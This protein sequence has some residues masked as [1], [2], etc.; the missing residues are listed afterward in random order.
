MKR[1]FTTLFLVVLAAGLAHAQSA[2]HGMGTTGTIPVWTNNSS[3]IGNSVLTQSGGNV[4]NASGKLA[5][6]QL[7]STV[8]I[9]T[10]PLMVTSTTQVPNLNASSLGGFGPTGFVQNSPM[11]QQSGSFNLSGNGTLGGTLNAGI[12][13]SIGLYQIGGTPVVVASSADDR[14][15][16]GFG[17]LLSNN[18]GTDNTA[19]GFNAL[20]GN[21]GGSNNTAIGSLALLNNTVGAFN[22]ASGAQALLSNVDGTDN[23][24][25]G[26]LALF[27]NTHGG[28]NTASGSKALVSNTEGN[29][30]T[31]IGASALFSNTT[32]LHNTALGADAG[33]FLVTGVSNIMVGHFAGANFTTNESENIDIGNAGTLGDGSV[34]DH[35]VIRVGTDATQDPNCLNT[36]GCQVATFI[37]AIHGVT[38]GSS[39]T[40]AVLV[41][42][43]GQLGTIASSRR[44]K[45]AIQD[46]GAASDGLLRLRPVTFRYKKAF[47]DGTKP[48]Q[49]GLVAEEVAEVY[50]DLVVRGKDGQ[51][52]TV[53]YYKLDAMLL[54]EIQKLAKAHAADQAEI[55]ELKSQ[56]ADQ[57]KQGQEQQAAMRQLLDQVRVIQAALD[58]TSAPKTATTEVAAKY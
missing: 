21:V 2:V 33:E 9:G 27:S 56:V 44:Y 57:L 42:A 31:A 28:R 8:P 18:G 41:D 38:T 29:D 35:G 37:A 34:A 40:S 48:I 39:T 22:T 26:Y 32:G 13:N 46:M 55:P 30:N 7:V 6:T 16:I 49:Y 53:Q 23:T 10:P 43:N 19:T 20:E 25:S 47:D 54:N 3:T 58:G 17:A 36:V 4:T 50:P 45:E 52:E 11:S 24:A 15:A 14:T 1:I 12:V 5:G 51:V